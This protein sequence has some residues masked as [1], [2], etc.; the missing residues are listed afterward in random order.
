MQII[1]QDPYSS[2]NPRMTV[3]GIIGEAIE[4][5]GVARGDERRRM[6]EDLLERVGLQPSYITRYPHEFSGGQRQRL[7]IA[8]ALALNPSFIVCDEAV[9]ALDVSV[10]AQ[11]INLLQDLQEE[12]NLSYLFIAHDLSVV[13]HISDRI[14]VMYLGQVMELASADNL[15]NDPKH[16][17]TQALLSAIPHPN[18]RRKK[19]RI[20]LEGDVPSP[21]N[22]PSGCVFHTRCPACFEPC[23]KVIPKTM[24]PEPGHFVKCHLYD[25]EYADPALFDRLPDFRGEPVGTD[26]T[27]LGAE[28]ESEPETST[29]G[30]DEASEKHD[31]AAPPSDGATSEED[32][33][34]QGA[35]NDEEE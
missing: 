8:R 20:I 7:G 33:A 31:E 17:Y 22:P 26:G 21:I 34:P 23:D 1:F 5:H 32:G 30:A 3:E 19:T 13:R 4:F 12:F 6:V 9:S 27:T 29:K 25:P 15:F 11:V 18:P 14:A 16:P 10:Q 2:L 24:E 28:S 35:A